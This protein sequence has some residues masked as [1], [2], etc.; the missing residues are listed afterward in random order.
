MVVTD[1]AT[2]TYQVPMTYRAAPLDGA[3]DALIGKS[4][5]GVLGLRYIYDGPRDPVLVAQ[6]V[7]LIQGD[8]KPQ[9]QSVSNTSDLTVIARPA[10]NGTLTATGSEVADGPSGT[11]LTVGTAHPDAKLAIRIN[12]ILRPADDAGQPGVSAPWRLP[13]GTQARGIFATAQ[14]IP[15]AS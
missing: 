10:T 9:A 4:E 14:Y 15:Q 3:G 2:T 1:R 8:A 12:R 13:G 11:D 7:A 6:L 5:H